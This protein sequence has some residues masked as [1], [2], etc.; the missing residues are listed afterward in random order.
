MNAERSA[1]KVASVSRKLEKMLQTFEGV[2]ASQRKLNV[3]LEALWKTQERYT[4][5]ESDLLRKIASAEE[6]LGKMQVPDMMDLIHS[7]KLPM[8]FGPNCK[9]DEPWWLLAGDP[10]LYFARAISRDGQVRRQWCVI[11]VVKMFRQVF[12]GC[13][14]MKFEYDRKRAYLWD[15]RKAEFRRFDHTTPRQSFNMATSLLS[16]WFNKMLRYYKHRVNSN[17][18]GHASLL[19]EKGLDVCIPFAAFTFYEYEEH[20]RDFVSPVKMYL[21]PIFRKL[22]RNMDAFRIKRPRYYKVSKCLKSSDSSSTGSAPSGSFA[23]SEETQRLDVTSP[24]STPTTVV[25]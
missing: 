4:A 20:R 1:K 7:T 6:F 13:A 21:T 15:N 9:I 22:N 8:P 16:N 5:R 24:S 19:A 25:I 2:R 3:R 12:E 11:D 10:R 17:P 18:K 23:T 14:A